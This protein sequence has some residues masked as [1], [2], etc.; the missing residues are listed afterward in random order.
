MKKVLK[1]KGITLIALAITVIILIILSTVTF[2]MVFG[3]FGL[4]NQ[5]MIAKNMTE[6]SVA[7]EQEKLN[8]LLE[9]L[10]NEK[11]YTINIDSNLLTYNQSLGEFTIIY[12][13]IGKIG[14][15]TIY[16][17]LVN[18]TVDKA[19]SNLTTINVNLP[20]GTVLTIQPIYYSPNYDLL[21]N[22]IVTINITDSL[23]VISFSYEY[24]GQI[25][26]TSYTN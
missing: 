17:D 26:G 24:N 8:K 12:S 20:E 9:E 2:S 19:E 21:S 13:V 23:N 22:E 25:I 4:I 6:N 5:A 3:E 7:E 10:A 15:N 18:V 16:E 14:E 11:E 1:E